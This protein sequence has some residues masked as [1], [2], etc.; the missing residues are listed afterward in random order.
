MFLNFMKNIYENTITNTTGKG[1]GLTAF[2]LRLG[3]RLYCIVTT[4]QTGLNML[5]RK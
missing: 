3:T 4:F 2:P 1:E 5:D